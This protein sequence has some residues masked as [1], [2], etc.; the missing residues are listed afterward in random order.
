[1]LCGQSETP[2]L[3]N[4]VGCLVDQ[5]RGAPSAESQYQSWLNSLGVDTSPDSNYPGGQISGNI[6]LAAAGGAAGAIRDAAATALSDMAPEAAGIVT[7][8]RQFVFGNLPNG[9]L[10]STDIN[11]NITIQNGLTGKIFDETLRHETVHSILTP[12]APF[13]Q[14]TIG[15][16]SY[17]GLY[18]YAEEAAAET[19]GTGS[20]W[21]GLRFPI[22][23]GYVSIPRLGVELAVAGSGAGAASYGIYLAA[24]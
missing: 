17:S 14:I 10:G 8:S 5:L 21:Q 23:N 22:A 3:S 16:Y 2:L 12:P 15:L 13:N 20:L 18:R 7:R 4:P 9:V 19:Y 6:L 11:G 24:R 1:M